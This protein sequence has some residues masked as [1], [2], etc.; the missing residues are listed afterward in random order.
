MGWDFASSTDMSTL[1]ERITRKS[2]LQTYVTF[3]LLADRP[4]VKDSMSG[5]AYFRWLDDEIDVR[6]TAK[7]DRVAFIKRQKHIINAAYANRHTDSLVP[8]ERLITG[9]ISTNRDRKSKLGSFISNFIKIIEFDA[10]RKGSPV[11]GKELEW[12]SETLSVAVIDCIEYFINHGFAYPK[13]PKQYRAAVGA[14]IV[15]MLRDYYEDLDEGFI[16]IPKEYLDK[17][18]ID[19]GETGTTAFQ[20][21]VRG[22]VTLARRY[23]SQGMEY[24]AE[25]PVLR[26]KLAAFWYCSRFENVLDTIENDGYVLRHRYRRKHNPARYVAILWMAIRV[27]SAHLFHRKVRV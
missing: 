13:S 19:P 23:L 22:Q 14:H 8:E 15:H 21:W 25:L 5:Y 2:S 3:K 7:L 20:N 16:N 1:G 10:A 6:R 4:L 11:T 18:G 27:V 26:G 9:L 12:Y 17:H 24:W